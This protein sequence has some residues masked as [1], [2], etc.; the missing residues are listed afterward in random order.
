MLFFPL[1]NSTPLTLHH[2]GKEIGRKLTEGDG[3][4]PEYTICQKVRSSSMHWCKLF[5]R[6]QKL[7]HMLNALHRLSAGGLSDHVQ[8]KSRSSTST[9]LRPIMF[10]FF[11]SWLA[12]SH[13]HK[14]AWNQPMRDRTW[15]WM[16]HPE[17]DPGRLQHLQLP[18]KPTAHFSLLSSNAPHQSICRLS[19]A[20]DRRQLKL[21]E[22]GIVTDVRPL[23]SVF[24]RL[25]WWTPPCE[26][27]ITHSTQK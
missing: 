13:Y 10:F 4:T 8:F 20:S 6:F 15:Y 2:Q 27:I 18:V 12:S 3:L 19:T 16:A 14:Q 7:W 11:L 1:D 17:P 24:G 25:W 9:S 21:L 23:Y 26:E 22:F 5:H